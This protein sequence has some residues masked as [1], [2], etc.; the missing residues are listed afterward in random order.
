MIYAGADGMWNCFC[1]YPDYERI[2]PDKK[3]IIGHKRRMVVLCAADIMWMTT[4]QEQLK[5]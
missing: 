3:G 2:A 4:W 5:K 1:I